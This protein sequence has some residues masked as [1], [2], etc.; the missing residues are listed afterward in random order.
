MLRLQRYRQDFPKFALQTNPPNLLQ[1]DFSLTGGRKIG[2]LVHV[3]TFES[4]RNWAAHFFYTY[5]AVT[6]KAIEE[7]EFGENTGSFL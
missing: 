7:L 1:N 4:A 6:S 2:L 5:F 3:H